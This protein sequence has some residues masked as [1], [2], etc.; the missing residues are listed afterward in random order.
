M[1]PSPSK[2]SRRPQE[3]FGFSAVALLAFSTTFT[4]LTAAFP[5]PLTRIRR[6]TQDATLL[7]LSALPTEATTHVPQPN[8]L[9]YYR[10]PN[11][12]LTLWVRDSGS[13]LPII[14][15]LACIHSLGLYIMRQIIAYGGDSTPKSVEYRHGRVHLAFDPLPGLNLT[16]AGKVADAME[17]VVISDNWTFASHFTVI[18]KEKGTVG[19]LRVMHLRSGG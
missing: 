16:G 13:R 3:M 10:I 12:D 14:D 2:T 19:H 18:D 9:F 8:E 6:A 17:A 7:P 4:S 11:T 1:T 15:I 5:R